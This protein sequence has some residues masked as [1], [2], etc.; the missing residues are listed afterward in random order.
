M[1]LVVINPLPQTLH[2]YTG[3]ILR[4]AEQRASRV[5]TVGVEA[6]SG[7]SR[8]R[9]AQVHISA[10]R[11]VPSTTPL[12]LT[13]PAFGHAEPLILGGREARTALTFHDPRPLRRQAGHGM[14]AVRLGPK[15]ARQRR[16]LVLSHSAA[17]T[18][19]LRALGY[20]EVVQLPLPMSMPGNLVDGHDSVVRVLGQHKRVRDLDLLRSLG[21]RLASMGLTCEIVGRDWPEIP[22]WRRRPH[23]VPEEEFD[24]LLASSAAILIPYSEFFQSDVAVRASE[25]GTPVVGLGESHLEEMLGEDYDGLVPVTGEVDQWVAAVSSVLENRDAHSARCVGAATR[26]DEQWRSLLHTLSGTD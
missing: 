14:T 5:G 19:V 20:S 21:P 17:A 1:S 2:H 8:W 16:L 6:S 11:R 13:W 12:L 10:V 26:A 9:R 3:E 4:V 23:F 22:G 18:R 15:L 24:A 7:L 25:H